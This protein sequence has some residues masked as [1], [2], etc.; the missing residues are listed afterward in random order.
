MKAQFSKTWNTSKQPRKQRKYRHNA[1]LH[2]RRKYLSAHLSKH[3]QKEYGR[4][5]AKIRTEDLVKVMRGEYAGKEG[6]IQ[7]MDVSK[8]VVFIEGISGKRSGGKEFNVPIQASNV[9]IVELNLKDERRI[10]ALKKIKKTVKKAE[11]PAKIKEEK[12]K[13]EAKEIKMS[14]NK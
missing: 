9:R 13:S 12:P 6:K 8:S 10:N 4:R 11:K 2:V 1:P 5:S 14:L 3:L 7:K